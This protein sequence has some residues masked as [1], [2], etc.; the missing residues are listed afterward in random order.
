MSNKQQIIKNINHGIVTKLVPSSILGA[1]VGIQ[2]LT[3]IEKGEIVFAPKENHFIQW[4]ELS[5][6]NSAVI[7]Y[8]KKVCNNNEYGFWIDCQI[9]DI[10]AAYFVNHSDEPNL[11]HDTQ[12]DIYIAIRDV[13]EGEEL[14]C[15]YSPEEIDWV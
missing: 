10:G 13:G 12:N 7:N 2:T 8:I 1:G 4:G 3:N 6:P 5:T 9:N 15:K 11:H 14:T